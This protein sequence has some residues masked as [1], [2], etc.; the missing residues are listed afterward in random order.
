MVNKNNNRQIG[1]FVSIN[2]LDKY[3]IILHATKMQD[4]TRTVT[5]W[6]DLSLLHYNTVYIIIITVMKW[7][8]SHS[9][10]FDSL[11]LIINIKFVP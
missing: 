4:V 10:F 7:T 8:Q 1:L 5:L 3:V 2:S 11:T 6:P 9:K